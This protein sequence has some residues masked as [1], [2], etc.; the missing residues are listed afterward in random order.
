MKLQH[1]AQIQLSTSYFT[2]SEL[3]DKSGFA[4]KTRGTDLKVSGSNPIS[5][6]GLL[7]SRLGQP[8]SILVFVLP[9][10]G[11]ATRYMF[12]L[13]FHPNK[14]L[15][16]RLFSVENKLKPPRLINRAGFFVTKKKDRVRLG[17]GLYSVRLMVCP[18]GVF[19][20]K[21]AV[22]CRWLSKSTDLSDRS[23]RSAP[24]L[25]WQN[26]TL[27]NLL[28]RHNKRSYRDVTVSVPRRPIE[29]YWGLSPRHFHTRLVNG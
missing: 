22:A 26:R 28:T 1:C 3:R 5:T 18:Q 10:G 13:N 6:S 11:I 17:N 27:A 7:L 15:A 2:V 19:A 9:S 8:D 23:R 29:L 14:R 4:R 12:E 20:R 16:G 21:L 24:N 25:A